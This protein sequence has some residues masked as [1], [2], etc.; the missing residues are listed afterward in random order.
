MNVKMSIIMPVFNVKDYL[1][2]SIT[3]ILNQTFKEV[4]LIL[5]DDGSKD[6]S[7]QICDY[8]KTVDDRIVVIHQPNMGS[9]SAR[10]HA[11]RIAKGDYIGFVDSDDVIAPYMYQILLSLMKENIDIVECEYIEFKENNKIS[12]SLNESY[13]IFT[14]IEAFA[15][16]IAEKNFKQIIW[17]KVY[18]KKILEDIFFPENKRIDDEFWTYKV[19]AKSR[20]CIHCDSIMYG[21]RQHN[22]SIMHDINISKRIQTFEANVLRYNFVCHNIPELANEACARLLLATLYYGQLA[23]GANSQEGETVFKYVETENK[24]LDIPDYDFKLS[25]KIW[26]KL[27][28]E[29]FRLVCKIRNFL[30]L[31]VK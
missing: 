2:E 31:G 20:N 30:K 4:E 22:N 7:S 17:N 9:G 25:H 18:R 14:K 6:G 16:H 8:W 5:V 15:D 10:N 28:R 26:I 27:S 21:Y 1:N 29:H 23:I 12:Y 24:K 13:K 3:S 11:L 19:I